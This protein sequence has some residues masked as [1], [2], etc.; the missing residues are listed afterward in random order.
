MAGVYELATSLHN[1]GGNFFQNVFK[2]SLSE[3]GSGNS[4]WEYAHDLLTHWSTTVKAKY[5]KLFGTDVTLDFFSAKKLNS[6]GGPTASFIDGSFGT[7]SGVCTSSGASGDVQWQSAS[8][9]NRPGHTYLAAFADG[10][11]QQDAFQAPYTTDIITWGAQMLVPLTLTGAL[12]TATF[13]IYSRKTDSFHPATVGILR[14]K[15]TMMNRRLLPQ[16]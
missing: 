13:G 8:P 15:A 10:S 16:I 9:L 6:G 11:L 7:G 2:Y 14:P 1:S 5:L 12:G 4:P 3:S